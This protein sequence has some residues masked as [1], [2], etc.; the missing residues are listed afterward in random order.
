MNANK[1]DYLDLSLDVSGRI[2]DIDPLLP[3]GGVESFY[4]EWTNPRGRIDTIDMV[5]FSNEDGTMSWESQYE[6][7]E[8]TYDSD[9]H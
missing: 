6:P 4:L 7:Y 1:R 3:Q 9:S 2:E 8:V 5:Q